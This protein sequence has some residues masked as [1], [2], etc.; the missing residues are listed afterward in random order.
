MASSRSGSLCSSL[1]QAADGGLRGRRRLLPLDLAEVRRLDADA[2]R[3]LA[4][5]EGP[6][7]AA[8]GFAGCAEVRS[9]CH[10]YNILH[11]CERCLG[12]VR[13]DGA[14]AGVRQGCQATMADAAWW[15]AWGRPIHPPSS[16][17][18]PRSRPRNLSP[19]QAVAP[20]TRRL[21]P[22][23]CPLTLSP[24]PF[25]QHTQTR[26]TVPNRHSPPTVIPAKA[27][28]QGGARP[29][30]AHHLPPATP[31]PSPHMAVA[32]A[33]R[34]GGN[35]G[36]GAA[37]RSPSPTPRHP[38]TL[39]PHG[40]RASDPR[41]RESRVGRGPAQPITYPPA[42]PQPSPHMAVAPA[43]REGGNPGWGAA[44]RSPSPTPRHPATLPPHGRR[45]SDPRRRESRVGARPCAAHHLPPAP[46]NPPPT[47]PSRQRP[48]KAGIQG[49]ARPC[50]AHHLP[51]RHPATLPPHDRRASDPRKRESRVAAGLRSPHK[52]VAQRPA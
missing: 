30:A 43:T 5:G 1:R 17:R 49:G 47:W 4:D 11:T 33:T 13:G 27:G 29:C 31:Q 48:V 42:T 16:P 51:P 2:L 26:R 20:A 37:L 10:V 28:I 7:L 46:R 3:D 24:L 52:A 14:P 36:W 18:Y 12:V 44:L 9:K 15:G 34:E 45:A 50:A 38:A 19:S 41:R 21:P 39:P 40:R 23:H 22:A 6:V 8:E 32:P 25:L 35:L